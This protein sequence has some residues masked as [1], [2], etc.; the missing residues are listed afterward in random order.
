MLKYVWPPEMICFPRIM[1]GKRSLTKNEIQF[2]D[3]MSEH[4]GI[5][6]FYM[7]CTFP[8]EEVFGVH[9]SGDDYVNVYANYKRGSGVLWYLTV[10]LHRGDTSEEYIYILD[11]N[12]QQMI[13]EAMDLYCKLLTGLSL[14]E[15]EKTLSD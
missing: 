9:L 14:E 7:P 5:I 6:D 3:D 1:T 12:E 15:Y 2:D 4:D 13:G 11:M 10:V 8:T